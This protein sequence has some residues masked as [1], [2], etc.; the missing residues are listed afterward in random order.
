MNYYPFVNIN[1]FGRSNQITTFSKEEQR[2]KKH[3]NVNQTLIYLNN[4]IEKVNNDMD[5]FLIDF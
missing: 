5:S 4:S 2:F 3:L 1:I